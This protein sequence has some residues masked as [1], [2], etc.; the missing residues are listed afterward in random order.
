MGPHQKAQPSPSSLLHLIKDSET[1]GGLRSSLNAVK[2]LSAEAL[3]AAACGAQPAFTVTGPR[4]EQRGGSGNQEELSVPITNA[5]VPGLRIDQAPTRRL[6]SDPP[7]LRQH[8][9]RD[10]QLQRERT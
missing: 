4:A 8:P 6:Y 7:Q 9:E 2:A 5:F 1:K 3:A 10:G